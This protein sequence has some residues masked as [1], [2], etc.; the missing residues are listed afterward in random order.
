[1]KL[2]RLEYCLCMCIERTY[3]S[4]L[5]W[6]PGYLLGIGRRGYGAK[7]LILT[8]IGKEAFLTNFILSSYSFLWWNY[9]V[10]R[11]F[12][13]GE[14]KSNRRRWQPHSTWQKR[15]R[16]PPTP[17]PSYQRAIKPRFSFED[18]LI[19]YLGITSL[20]YLRRRHR[21]KLTRQNEN[22]TWSG[23]TLT[24]MTII[25]GEYLFLSPSFF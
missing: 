18:L 25:I 10:P 2:L 4:T 24:W 6:E 8:L 23:C 5:N 17:T 12:Q 15:L 9:P 13:L 11:P 20:K 22:V 3:R 7:S 21:L 1:M 14:R 19:R 16:Y